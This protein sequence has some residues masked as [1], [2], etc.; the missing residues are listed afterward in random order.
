MDGRKLASTLVDETQLTSV[1]KKR[2]PAKLYLKTG[3]M[4]IK[5]RSHIGQQDFTSSAQIFGAGLKMS[6]IEDQS[7][8]MTY[9][10]SPKI[11][12]NRF[13]SIQSEKLRWEELEIGYTFENFKIKKIHSLSNTE[14]FYVPQVNIAMGLDF[15]RWWGFSSNKDQINSIYLSGIVPLP[16]QGRWISSIDGGFNFLLGDA[17]KEWQGWGTHLIWNTSVHLNPQKVV[18]FEVGY[19]KIFARIKNPEYIQLEQSFFQINI[20]YQITPK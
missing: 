3:I 15:K 1:V 14:Q 18:F 7:I 17:S 4:E 10:V 12:V 20:G 8:H 9:S 19:Q 16:D 5:S 6:S 2:P 13:D 11:Y